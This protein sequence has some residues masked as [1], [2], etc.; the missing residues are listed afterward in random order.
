M[1]LLDVLLGTG[2]RIGEATSLTWNDIDFQSGFIS[3]NHTFIYYKEA[4]KEKKTISS[5]KTAAGNRKIPMMGSKKSFN[6]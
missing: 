1:L 4:G 3:V 5:P 6:G 2:M